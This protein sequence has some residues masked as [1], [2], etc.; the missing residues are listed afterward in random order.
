MGVWAK[1][2]VSP[3]KK[4]MRAVA[5]WLIRWGISFRLRSLND[6][7]AWGIWTMDRHGGNTAEA[8]VPHD[9]RG[10][11]HVPVA[12]AP[13]PGFLVPNSG[14]GNKTTRN[15]R[16]CCLFNFLFLS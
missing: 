13:S 7:R 12:P 16:F 2:G 15:N 3:T 1:T 14:T 6:I 4:R 5:V 10:F 8:V 9:F 11:H